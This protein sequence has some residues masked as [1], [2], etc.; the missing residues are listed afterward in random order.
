MLL[1]NIDTWDEERR[2]TISPSLECFVF[3]EDRKR[4]SA[5]CNKGCNLYMYVFSMLW[6]LLIKVYC[7]RYC[8]MLDVV[9]CVR[10]ST[11]DLAIYSFSYPHCKNEIIV[12]TYSLS[13]WLQMSEPI[14]HMEYCGYCM[15]IDHK[16]TSYFDSAAHLM[17]FVH[18]IIK[19]MI[20]YHSL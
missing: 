18:S 3:C 7:V 2:W 16:G 1:S 10:A 19:E 4:S 17:C 5:C 20:N 12:V 11:E 13:F 14:A 8:I 6:C 9:Q 15:T